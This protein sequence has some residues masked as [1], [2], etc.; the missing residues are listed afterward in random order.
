MVY[1]RIQIKDMI[2]NIIA[3]YKSQLIRNIEAFLGQ[4]DFS[5]VQTTLDLSS[6][7]WSW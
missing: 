7:T 6:G 2:L 3:C 1:R 5:L 4:M